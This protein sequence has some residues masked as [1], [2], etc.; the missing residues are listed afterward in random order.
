MTPE[1]FSALFA[2]FLLLSVSARLWLASRQIRHV[3]RH[4]HQLPAAFARRIGLTAHQ[5][6]AAYTIARS[7][8][9][10]F[11]LC[12]GAM[13]L[14]LLTLFGGLQA[15]LSAWQGWLPD[16]PLL[17]Q[18]A[19][20]IS[21]TLLISLTELPLELWRTFRLE[22]RFGFNRMS[23][24]LFITDRLKGLVVAALLGLPLL[25]GMIWLMQRSGGLWWFWTWLLWL[26][27]S[28]A[29]LLLYPAVIAPW[30]N[31]FEPMPDGVVRQRIEALLARC[32]FASSGLFV[33]DG[34]RRSAHGNAY[35]TGLGKAR[36]IVFFDTLLER[37]DTAEIEAVLAH[38]LGH[39]KK[40]HIRKRLLMQMAFSFVAF[41]LLGWLSQQSWFYQ[42]LGIQADFA[43]TLPAGV[44]LL[45]FFLVM[46]VFSFGLRPLMAWLSRRDEFEA[47]AF[48]VAHS[49]GRALVSALAKLYEDNASTL[50]PDPLHSA[51]YDSHPPA[52]IRI[53]R[54]EQAL[55]AQP[56]AAC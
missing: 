35:F 1:T 37:L 24:G 25:A 53:A 21:A 50:T 54:I 38:E 19:I 15:I 28:T 26:G 32:G 39:F 48:A 33:M 51:F 11:E 2:T 22:N 43:A 34:S 9:G 18:T 12:L 10:M 52:A 14:L 55:P 30:F 47:D 27:F 5:R 7:Q 4:Q 40:Q 56:G 36:R 45:L 23:L 41:A 42:G 46:P 13:V 31:R 44:A 29:V 3:Q 49:D 6:A 16:S 8:L 20:V 17:A